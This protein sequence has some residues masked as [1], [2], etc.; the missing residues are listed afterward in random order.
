MAYEA[1]RSF[2]EGEKLGYN[3]YANLYSPLRLSPC[4]GTV[5]RTVLS[6]AGKTSRLTTLKS[7]VRL[8]L[9][10]FNGTVRVVD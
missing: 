5:G 9:K 7:E 2:V 6:H 8:S 10:F 3:V 4:I 1:G